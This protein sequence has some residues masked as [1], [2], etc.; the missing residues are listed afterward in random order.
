MPGN[1]KDNL[2]EMK[3]M[4]E[5]IL[6]LA[7]SAL[8]L[9]DETIAAEVKEMYQDIRSLEDDTLKLLFR[10]KHLEDEERLVLIDMI[11]EIKDVAQNARSLAQIVEEHPHPA[12][13]GDIL[14]EADERVIT[15]KIGEGSELVDMKTGRDHLSEL[16]GANLVTVKRGKQ[17]M[18]DID[19][20]T[21]KTGDTLIAVGSH[22]AAEELKNAAKG[23]TA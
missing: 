21:V 5:L 11:D 19:E 16:T 4:S 20:L 8:F 1:V 17:Y 12:I 3:N 13:V 10:V 22:A 2:M 7:Y 18:F 6:D 15:V 14:G 23:N 9:Q